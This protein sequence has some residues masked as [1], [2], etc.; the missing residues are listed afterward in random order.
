MNTQSPIQ[1]AIAYIPII[2]WLYVY[3][4]QR[5]NPSAIF[6]L[7]QSIGL[8]LF[9]IGT[10]VGWAIVAYL[11]GLIPYMAAFSVALFTIVIA[12][13][14]FGALT[15]VMGIVNALKNKS[16][17]LPIFGRWASRLPIT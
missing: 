9:L 8:V 1:A 3:V 7:R 16:I 17:P 11:I 6:H 14:F 2:G 4:L 12:A 15:L 13:Y 5:K 10:L